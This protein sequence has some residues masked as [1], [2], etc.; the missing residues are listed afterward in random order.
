MV[1]AFA[2][3]ASMPDKY[4][5]F[6]P[7]KMVPPGMFAGRLD[8]IEYI[9]GCLR[10]ARM[11]NPKH[12][13]VSG[14]RGIGKSSLVLYTQYCARGLLN[15][16][17]GYDFN[18]TVLN[19]S[20]RNDDNFIAIIDRVAK[21]L[22]RESD[23]QSALGTFVSKSVEFLS[24]FEAAGV[25]YNAPADAGA[26]EA[27][28]ALLDD[29]ETAILR[30]GDAYDGILLLIDEADGPESTANLGLFCKLLTE[31]MAKRGT[32][33]VCIGLAGLPP[34]VTK[35]SESHQSSLR[36]FHVL[37]LKPLEVEERG[38]VLEMGIRDANQKNRTPCQ[39][40]PDAQDL[41]SEYSEG[42]PHFL[43]EFAYCAFEQDSNN[44]IDREDFI[45]SLF[46]EN[47][48]FDQLGVK[49]FDRQYSTPASNDYRKVLHVMSERLDGWITRAEIISEGG[50]KAGTVDNALRALKLKGIIVQDEARM[51]YYRLPTRSFAAWINIQKKAA[52]V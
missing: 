13:L 43:Q 4:N 6:R 23:K 51:G 3:G 28:S 42:Y 16:S 15:V 34:L 48:A 45:D 20:L 37:G 17:A 26:D 41:I 40:E 19:V 9:L 36:L 24:R 1:Q 25:K 46:G 33:K 2:K 5:P 12:F 11:G 18:F 39:I 27:L 7:D 50:L 14:E 21:A 47:G 31:E 22:K 49:Y 35:L 29:F 8:E 10:Q 52:T 38:M 32:D 44:V 30:A